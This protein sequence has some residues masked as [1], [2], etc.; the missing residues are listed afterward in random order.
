MP[1][2]SFVSTSYALQTSNEICS[3]HSS[4]QGIDALS[5]FTTRLTQESTI[6]VIALSSIPSLMGR[7]QS[8]GVNRSST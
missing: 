8:Q 4:L 5:P 2:S 3:N 7:H 6:H 1:S